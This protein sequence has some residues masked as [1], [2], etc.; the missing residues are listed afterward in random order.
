VQL[1][2]DTGA[3]RSLVRTD[4]L[5]AVGYDPSAASEMV[6]MTTGSSV[7]SVP[8][9]RVAKVEALEQERSNFLIA[10]HTLPPTAGVDGVLGLDFL[11]RHR[12]VVDFCA[13]V[14]TLD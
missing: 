8:Q 3:T 10:C 11:R 4:A 14:V 1:A 2:L 9:I 5:T 7:E 12:L 13:G 6:R